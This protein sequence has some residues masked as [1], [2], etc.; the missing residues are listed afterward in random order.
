[1]LQRIAIA[2]FS[3]YNYIENNDCLP[4]RVKS[5]SGCIDTKQFVGVRNG[6]QV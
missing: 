4:L 2:T 6:V 5:V 3:G 1:M